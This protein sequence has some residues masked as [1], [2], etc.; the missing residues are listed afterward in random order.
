MRF[1]ELI[2]GIFYYS[3]LIVSV[4]KYFFWDNVT[5]KGN[6]I[7]YLEPLSDQKRKALNVM[8]PI[9]FDDKNKL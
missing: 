4:N 3:I 1:M 8:I 9:C 2:S 5:T 7:E 6:L